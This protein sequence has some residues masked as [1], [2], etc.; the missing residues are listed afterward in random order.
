MTLNTTWNS[1]KMPR[2]ASS[3][4]HRTP[5]AADDACAETRSLALSVLRR[6]HYATTAM[7]EAPRSFDSRYAALSNSSEKEK[8][9]KSNPNFNKSYSLSLAAVEYAPRLPARFPAPA[10][11]AHCGLPSD[12]RGR[13]IAVRCAG[14]KV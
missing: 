12:F 3:A 4:V 6:L 8:Y 5:A 7:N 13:V 9:L 1:C 10:A 2:S 14:T 11:C